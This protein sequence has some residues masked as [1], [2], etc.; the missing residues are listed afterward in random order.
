MAG[1]ALRISQMDSSVLDE[2]VL[3]SLK[4]QLSRCLSLLGLSVW[5]YDSTLGQQMLNVKYAKCV[6]SD[7]SD[8]EEALGLSRW[9][10][11]A[12]GLV[13]VCGNYCKDKA[14]GIEVIGQ[15]IN[16]LNI[17]EK[18]RTL[19][20]WTERLW[21]MARLVNFLIFLQQ[22]SYRSLIERILRL[23]TV[24]VHKQPVRQVSFEF[25]NRELLW[26][27]FAE[28]TFFLLP[29]VNVRRLR[30]T[31][32]RVF[33]S[34]SSTSSSPSFTQC[35]ICESRPTTPYQASCNHIFCYY[36]IKANCMADP[37]FSCPLCS[38]KIQ[39]I[40]AAHKQSE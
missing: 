7:A 4:L 23:N 40:H 15:Y 22:G 16:N 35:G 24:L 8:S 32:H 12:Y 20:R 33:T 11:I 37:G 38:S 17:R 1:R 6:S 30:N 28:F 14:V 39:S 5:K 19:S 18:I 10:K 31:V 36:C 27:S 29:F 26:H 2:E 25:M 34:Y 9:Q 13:F 21:N 3:E